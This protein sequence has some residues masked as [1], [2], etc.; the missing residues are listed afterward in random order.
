[1]LSL[2]IFASM[3]GIVFLVGKLLNAVRRI[4]GL[5]IGQ[6]VVSLFEAV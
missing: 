4:G 3:L 2:H 1:M 6:V 5:F